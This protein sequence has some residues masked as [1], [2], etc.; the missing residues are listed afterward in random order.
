MTNALELQ[1][2]KKK[3][4]D[5]TLDI[6]E[7]VL[8][9]GYILGLIGRNGAGKSTTLKIAMNMVYPD[10]GQVKVLGRTQPF[11]ELDIKRRVGYVEETPTFYEEM[12]IEWM[13]RLV[14]G[15]FPTWD[16]NLYG[17][18]LRKFDL[19]PKK[20]V[21][22]LSKGMKVKLALALALSH[23]PE[24]LVLDEP[25]SG[26]DPVVRRELLQEIG[27]VIKD[28]SR[29]VVFSSHITQDIEQIADYIA[30]LESGSLVEYSD[31][32]SLLDR[33]K[34]VSW[35]S[36]TPQSPGNR[37]AQLD[38]LF[39]AVKTDGSGYLGVTGS[40]SPELIADLRRLG[41]SNIKIT[42]ASL[43][44]LLMCLAGKEV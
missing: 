7:L 9:R 20:R 4:R 5:F 10:S 19:N 42:N 36:D 32:E 41:A 43:D 38:D 18:Y 24:L 17:S 37:L 16:D 14:S 21:K 27:E 3:Y 44:E 6:E 39:A 29:T 13:A 1:G 30:I 28:D 15:Y 34:K 11:E 12:T 22:E 33:W 31:K 25:A 40:Y 8:E 2:V 26:I 35:L 23:R